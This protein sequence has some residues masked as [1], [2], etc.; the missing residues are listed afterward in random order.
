MQEKSFSSDDAL[1]DRAAGFA[2]AD[3]SS[4]GSFIDKEDK[5]KIAGADGEQRLRE[6][7]TSVKTYGSF[8]DRKE[9]GHGQLGK[10]KEEDSAQVLYYE[11]EK[12]TS[13]VLNMSDDGVSHSVPKGLGGRP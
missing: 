10:D 2:S 3:G 8:R 4:V 11:V 5:R 1:S 9:E 13:C 7:P 6:A 12:D